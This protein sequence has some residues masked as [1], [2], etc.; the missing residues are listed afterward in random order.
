[1]QNSAAAPARQSVQSGATSEGG[2]GQD[3]AVCPSSIAFIRQIDGKP[4]LLCAGDLGVGETVRI[5]V[6]GDQRSIARADWDA[7]PLYRG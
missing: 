6:D 5:S 1:M 2:G 4:A 7:A 3:A